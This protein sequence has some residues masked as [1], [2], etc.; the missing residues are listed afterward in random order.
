M[1]MKRTSIIITAALGIGL[2]ACA[3]PNSQSGDGK[4]VNDST[5]IIVKKGTDKDT[6]SVNRAVKK[7]KAIVNDGKQ[8]VEQKASE[9]GNKAE[10]TYDKSKKAVT[11][12]AEKT[13]D[14]AEKVYDDSKKAVKDAADKTKEK[15]K[16]G[17]E[18]VK[19]KVNE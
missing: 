11:N 3:N 13:A 7:G 9:V 6:L 10:K 1:I 14:K 2:A 15:A 16:E 19:E 5:E 8:T 12:A 17:W 4:A 18:K